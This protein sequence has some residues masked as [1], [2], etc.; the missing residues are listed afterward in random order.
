MQI[1]GIE[2]QTAV[3]TM[4]EGR[5]RFSVLSART[6]S[7]KLRV[8]GDYMYVKMQLFPSR[9]AS[10]PRSDTSVVGISPPSAVTKEGGQTIGR[11]PSAIRKLRFQ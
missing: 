11:K 4:Q 7:Y 1:G 5:D 6:C 3:V 2:R 9:Q 8:Q 10:K